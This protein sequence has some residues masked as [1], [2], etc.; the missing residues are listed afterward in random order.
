M[1]FAKWKRAFGSQTAV[2]DRAERRHRAHINYVDITLPYYCTLLIPAA[3]ASP[4]VLA[5]QL[6]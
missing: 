4:T 1:L 5:N 2:A 6:L 3:V